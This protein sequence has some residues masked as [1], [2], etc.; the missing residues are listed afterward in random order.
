MMNRKRFTLIE[1]LVVIAI[2][3]ILA[4]MLLPA[5]SKAREKARSI[6]C[7]NNLKQIG[8]AVFLYA[9]DYDDYIVPGETKTPNVPWFSGHWFGLLSGW[10][11]KTCGYGPQYIDA[12]TTKGTFVCPSESA[13]F[14]HYNNLKFFYTH[15]LLNQQLSGRYDSA[16]TPVYG[17]VRTMA[18][19]TEPSQALFCGDS[20]RTS[21]WAGPYGSL[22]AY[23]HG[24]PDVREVTTAGNPVGTPSGLGKCQFVFMDGHVGAMTYFELIQRPS[25]TCYAGYAVWR[26]MCTGFDANR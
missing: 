24:S 6:S 26:Y 14:G 21:N 4:A 16:A 12:Y 17:T 13:Q 7:V 18:A 5:L 1:L 22:Y 8:L 11:D 3:A 10:G 23:R 19:L 9:S 25:E 2:I 20:L 15:Y